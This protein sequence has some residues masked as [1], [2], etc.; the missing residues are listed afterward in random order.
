MRGD[1][2]NEPVDSGERE[3]LDPRLAEF[4][5]LVRTIALEYAPPGQ[6]APPTVSDTVPEAPSPDHA[7]AESVDSATTTGVPCLWV[8]ITFK[9]STTCIA[10][11]ITVAKLA[12]FMNALGT[13]AH[14]ANHVDVQIYLQRRGGRKA[15][16]K[17][18]IWGVILDI[19]K[20]SDDALGSF[21]AA[22]LPMPTCWWPT[23]NGYKGAWAFD[24]SVDAEAFSMIAQE[25]AVAVPGAD[26]GSWL[27]TQGQN[28]P[29][30][31]KD[32]TGGVVNVAMA[33]SQSNGVPFEV[34]VYTPTL[35][36]RLARALAGAKRLTADERRQ[37][38]D[39]LTE[40]GIDAPAAPS[41]VI[42]DSCP[43][44]DKHDTTCCYV[45]RQED[46]SID[47]T[48]HGGHHG[49]GK[50]YW[51]EIALY[52]EATGQQLSHAE[53]DALDDVPFTWAGIEFV[54]S[55]FKAALA[56]DEFADAIIEAACVV[57]QRAKAAR[58]LDRLRA[59]ARSRGISLTSASVAVVLEIYR[60]KLAAPRGLRMV[61][62]HGRNLLGHVR[63]DQ[64]FQRTA[65]RASLSLKEHMHEW[66]STL[67]V[68]VELQV[69]EEKR[70]AVI[71]E[72]PAS[73]ATSSWNKVV[74][75]GDP[76]FLSAL[77]IPVAELYDLPIAH[78]KPGWSI[79]PA[80]GCLRWVRTARLK[81]G[82]ATFDVVGFFLRL[83]KGGKLPL[84]SEDDVR[85][86]I[87]AI[88]IG[89][90]RSHA[91]GLIGVFWFTGPSGAGKDW[92]AHLLVEIWRAAVEGAPAVSF[93]VHATD[94][95][96]QSRCFASAGDAVFARAREAG[97]RAAL[98]DRLIQFAGTPH[99]TA[100]DMGKLARNIP[101]TFVYI[102]DSVE[103]LPDRREI[104]RR[105]VTI[106]VE[107]VV[108]TSDRGDVTAEIVAHAADI[109]ASLLRVIETKPLDFY[110]RYPNKS[111][112]PTLPVA[113]AD[114]FGT[115]LPEVTG[116]SLAEL[117]GHI[118]A[119]CKSF[120]QSDE[121]KPRGRKKDGVETTLF[122]VHRMTH[123]ID[124]MAAQAGSRQFFRQHD[125]PRKIQLRIQQELQVRK[126]KYIRVAIEGTW[127]AFRIVPKTNNFI[128]ETE[129]E[130]RTKMGLGP[131]DLGATLQDE[132]EDDDEDKR[133]DKDAAH[134]GDDAQTP[135]SSDPP[136][137]MTSPAAS[138]PPAG[139]RKGPLRFSSS[140][141]K[142][143]FSN[144]KVPD[145][146]ERR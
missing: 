109:L 105:T 86:F 46:G 92:L 93:D 75:G 74:G 49:E 29:V 14:E 116:A 144:P 143:E 19:D 52:R 129:I 64:A 18:D 107:P 120:A 84:A 43:A 25:F 55:K 90:L 106:N 99:V 13:A 130:F 146:T 80:T 76:T 121:D 1:Q 21:L 59:Q 134:D 97:K 17:V 72:V 26:P 101:N 20:P 69:D 38:E 3:S 66:Y 96:E 85:R 16:E 42:Y 51:G 137:L 12:A 133:G 117:F 89:L 53:I 33:A 142:T 94:D 27:V 7:P 34:G 45:Y 102:A 24:R 103:D 60:R 37:V 138:S 67:A 15:N 5:Q 61:Y 6:P 77:G 100:R 128:F 57:W 88:A 141:L 131:D 50:K 39:W 87:I 48:C 127:Y 62:H 10:V 115:Q 110:I 78:L 22:G 23:R 122:P 95:L 4:E 132:D 2:N 28:L 113:L 65:C 104:S 70:I 135:R 111:S 56:M 119:Y 140:A 68:E 139:E 30:G 71:G 73:D 82:D 79:D 81:P 91:P 54:T 58:R 32:T 114:V 108:D 112:R 98:I 47:I 136:P 36:S 145:A 11:L 35:P 44:T 118:A 31:W 124:V 41:R 63:V 123:M 125:S 40:R 8:S 9:I 83:F 126:Q